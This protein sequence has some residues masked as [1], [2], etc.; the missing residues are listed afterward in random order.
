MN[1]WM[2]KAKQNAERGIEQK[3]GGPF[4]AVI[5]DKKGESDDNKTE[6]LFKKPCHD[7]GTDLS[8][9][10][11]QYDTGAHRGNLRGACSPGTDQDQC[12]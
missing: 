12:P 7:N 2:E 6:S 10:K 8:G 1:P 11:I 9:R 5:T 4:G 3:E